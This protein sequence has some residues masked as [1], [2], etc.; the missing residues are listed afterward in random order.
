MDFTN[1]NSLNISKKP[2]VRQTQTPLTNS[3]KNIV[4]S[5]NS[6]GKVKVYN[7][8]LGNVNASYRSITKVKTS[9]AAVQTQSPKKTT[10]KNSRANSIE[11][12]STRGPV[13][14]KLDVLILNDEPNAAKNQIEIKTPNR[15]IAYRT[16]N[17]FGSSIQTLK[18]S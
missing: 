5:M 1:R 10:R 18:N 7:D 17:D 3:Q 8:D 11:V 6:P 14:K 9:A 16:I 13:V 2:L 12:K 4:V 15:T